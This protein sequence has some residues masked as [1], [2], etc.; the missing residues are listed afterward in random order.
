MPINRKCVHLVPATN[1]TAQAID[2]YTMPDPRSGWITT[3]IA[4]RIASNRMRLVVSRSLRR[5]IL[6]TTKADNATTRS[7]LPSS[8]DCSLKNGRSIQRLDPRVAV[9][10]T[11]V[12]RISPMV[13]A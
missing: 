4:G 9:P 3:S 10:S 2:R 5:R 6:S 11:N 13:A 12:S 8:D 7:T 1:S